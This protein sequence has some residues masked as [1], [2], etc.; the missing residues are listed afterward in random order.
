MEVTES[1]F[2]LLSDNWHLRV[3]GGF[4][5]L[6]S[7]DP[8]QLVWYTLNKQLVT[9]LLLAD[10]KKTLGDIKEITEYLFSNLED[11]EAKKM[12]EQLFKLT[13]NQENP[14][15][16]LLVSDKPF[17]STHRYNLQE[18][19]KKIKEFTIND[20]EKVSSG[21]PVYPLSLTLIPEN[22]CA[23]DCIYCYA[24]RKK[25][26]KQEYMSFK[27]W[28]EIIEEASSLGIDL[29]VLTGG[30][31]L[32]YKHIFP[33][34]KEL[35]KRDFLFILP[36]KVFIT[37]E[38]AKKFKE[39]GMEKCWNQVSIDSFDDITTER[40]VKVKNYASKMFKSIQNM[41][42]EGLQVRVNC[43]ATPINCYEI[44]KL[45][46]KLNV[47]GVKQMS[48]SGYGRTNYRHKDEL[49][50]SIEQMD[51]LNEETD[52]LNKSLK[53]IKVN[54][55]ISPRDYSTLSNNEKEESWD[56]RSKCSA[57]RASLVINPTGE[58]TLCEQMP[59]SN[60]NIAGNLKN[61]GLKEL[62]NS[63]QMNE[64]TYPA[65]EKFKDSVCYDCD[66]FEECI[67][68]IGYC[69]RDSLFTYGSV[70]S[71]PPNCPKAP[72]GLRMQ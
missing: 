67:H 69:F 29:A 27:R 12:I 60:E 5:I 63:V 26:K 11:F 31:P 30:D 49:F 24:E 20:F 32:K 34:L 70:Y 19:L 25:I 38:M 37:K 35:I 33:L 62:W 16:L 64:L 55:N 59:L 66:D 3:E 58:V 39:I 9:V 18:T 51:W 2:L 53:N 4:G 1:Q 23:T 44:P 47:L 6:Y 17:E 7:Y 13:S 28:V 10:G 68:K 14:F 65:K 15:H 22:D 36:S 43:V 41:V 48:I 56:E 40:L 52:K 21:I 61:Q 57:G 8:E 42:S 45:I 46:E 71:P 50:L 54:C 72:I